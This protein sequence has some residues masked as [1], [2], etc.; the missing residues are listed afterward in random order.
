MGERDR[1]LLRILRGTSDA[2]IPFDGLCHLLQRL[3]FAERIRGSHHIFSKSGQPKIVV[4]PVHGNATLKPG[5]ATR[6]SKD[7][8][9]T[10]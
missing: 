6:L 2:N 4:V 3:D 10:W 8:G 7:T 5:L 9:I 1:L